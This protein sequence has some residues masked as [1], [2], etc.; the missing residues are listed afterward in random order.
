MPDVLI[1]PRAEFLGHANAVL[2]GRARQYDVRGFT[3]PLSLKSVVSGRATWTTAAGTFD[4]ETGCALVV[5]DGEEYDIA[6]DALQ[7]VETFCVFF[8]RGY[9][10]DAYRS[11]T[12]S[13]ADLIDA[14]PSGHEVEIG[15]RMIYD[16]CVVR[17]MRVEAIDELASALVRAVCDVD[18]RVASLPALRATTRDELRRRVRRAVDYVHC[19]VAS[20]L[21]LDDLASAA[22]LSP[23][24]FHRVFAAVYGETPKRYVC[25][26]RL[27][28]A[29]TMLRAGRSVTETAAECGFESV[30]SFTTLFGRTFGVTPGR[31]ATRASRR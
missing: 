24:H 9:V 27:E 8:R 28:R 1:N 26:V 4:V 30:G 14:P 15:E 3:G 22:C 5:N 20:R 11:A 6:I 16:A 31:V 2:S 10:A 13:S 17:N 18:A 29:R 19:N 7:P 12:S 25:R 23:F 21:A